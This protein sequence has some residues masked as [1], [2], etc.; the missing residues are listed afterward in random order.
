[1]EQR[2]SKDAQYSDLLTTTPVDTPVKSEDDATTRG[3]RAF[4][5]GEGL[6]AA[7][8]PELCQRESSGVSCP[9]CGLSIWIGCQST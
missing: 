2:E 8:S 1:M 9:Q 6:S 5:D 7:V 3:T 4:S